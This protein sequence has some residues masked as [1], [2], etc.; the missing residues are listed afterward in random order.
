MASTDT[1]SSLGKLKQWKSVVATGST[2]NAYKLDKFPVTITLVCSSSSGYIQ[3][4]TS[5][6]EEIDAGTATWSIWSR[7]TISST[8]TDIP[9]GPV[10][11]LRGVSSSGAV[12][13][14]VVL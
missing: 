11:G 1:I 8:A 2:G 7:G 12:T 6:Y 13:L 3:F 9:E 5:S 14:E 4:S 10:T